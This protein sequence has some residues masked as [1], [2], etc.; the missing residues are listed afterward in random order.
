MFSAS[1][2]Y[3]GVPTVAVPDRQGRIVR[4][5]QARPLPEVTGTFRHV[6][7]AGDRLDQLATTYYG[8]SRDWW[9]ICDANPD[10]LS[11]L[12]LLSDDPVV[13]TEFPLGDGDPPWARLIAAVQELSGVEHVRVVDDAAGPARPPWSLRVTHNRVTVAAEE[14]AAALRSVPVG[15][16]E[17]VVLD[18]LGREIVVPPP[19]T[20][21]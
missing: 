10:S 7:A 12:G 6:V 17:W 4:A 16:G 21:G 13:T 8:R 9:H 18:R 11:P 20:G 1:S 14:I 5:T 19:V 15:M 2:R 3:R